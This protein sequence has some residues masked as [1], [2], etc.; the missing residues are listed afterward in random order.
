MPRKVYSALAYLLGQCIRSAAQGTPRVRAAQSSRI[1]FTIFSNYQW[2]QARI[3][4]PAN[5]SGTS[6]ECNSAI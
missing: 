5:P 1:V 4:P 2:L 3:G 6:S